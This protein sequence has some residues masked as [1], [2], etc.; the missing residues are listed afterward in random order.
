MW[1]AT[2]SWEGPH[3]RS[4]TATLTS[5]S[6]ANSKRGS[7]GGPTPGTHRRRK[8]GLFVQKRFLIDVEGTFTIHLNVLMNAAGHASYDAIIYSSMIAI[9]YPF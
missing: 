1:R 5:R 3:I 2:G 7:R 9:F 8:V 4:G 6:P